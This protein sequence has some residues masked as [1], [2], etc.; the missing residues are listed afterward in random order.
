MGMVGRNRGVR[1]FTLVELLVVISIIGILIA[2]LLPA[3]QAAREA[4]RRAS[5]QNKVKQLG[6]AMANY[7]TL[8]KSFPINWGDGGKGQEY[9]HSWISF[10]LPQMEQVSLY[11]S[12]DFDEPFS[13]IDP[14]SNRKDNEEAAKSPL[15]ALYCPSD[16]H[17]GTMTNQYVGSGGLGVPWAVTNYKAVA[18]ANWGS[19]SG[20][21]YSYRQINDGY[22]GRNF[23]KNN[24][25][26]FG[27]GLI[28]RGVFDPGGSASTAK[29]IYKTAMMEVRDG[30]S[31]T[32]AI[33]EAIPEMCA[34][35]AWYSY[36]GST[37]TCGIPLN[38]DKKDPAF[39][40]DMANNYSFR[41]WHTSGANFG[42]CDASVHFI[43][44]QID[45][46][47]YRA[48]ATIDAG[49]VVNVPE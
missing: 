8:H 34:W 17:D 4:A 30:S 24:G 45:L 36:D 41:S 10:I 25:L 46:K 3:V 42:M 5:C 43:S 32:F 19:V 38:Y 21:D 23:N 14:S 26:D 44:D 22:G 47:T 9:G 20:S 39:D 28:C 31:N 49:E 40:Q 11:D 48:L 37:A 18:G 6:L 16:S 13:F 35:S 2:M 7:H 1:A 12:I 27:D 29:Q 15:N 33:G